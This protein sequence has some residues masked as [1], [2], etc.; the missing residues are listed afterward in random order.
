[1]FLRPKAFSAMSLGEI[2]STTPGHLKVGHC[3]ISLGPSLGLVEKKAS[4]PD[5]SDNFLSQQVRVE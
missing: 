1:M 3:L 2:P 4:L 5:S